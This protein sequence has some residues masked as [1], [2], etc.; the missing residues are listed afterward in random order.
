MKEHIHITHSP[1]FLFLIRNRNG[2]STITCGYSTAILLIAIIP[3][4]Q[5]ERNYMPVDVQRLKTHENFSKQSISSH[6]M[7]R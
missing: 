3:M 5:R 1:A 6:L 4:A 7:K 2:W